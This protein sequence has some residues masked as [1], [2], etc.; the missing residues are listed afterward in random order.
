[1]KW[2]GARAIAYRHED[3]RIQLTGRNGTDY[4]ARFPEITEAL[5]GVPGPLVLDGEIVV[6]SNGLP[7][8]S[9]LQGR[10]HR[11]RAASVRTGATT[12]PA[13]FIAFD[14]L[15]TDRP[16][17]AEP[18]LR[19]RAVLEGLD[20]DRPGLR[21]PPTWTSVT[22]AYGWT[23]EHRLEGV[24][25]KRADSPYTPGARTRHW[26]KIKHLKTADVVLGGW[27][28]GGTTG[29]TVRA[30]L[31]GAPV[32]PGR[33]TFVGSVGTGFATAERRALAATLRRL[34]TPLSPFAGTAGALG[35]PRGT[36]IRFVR[37]ELRAEVEFLELTPAG[38]LRHPVWRGLR[39]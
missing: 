20:L 8:F 15:H 27:L 34:A 5:A 14:V 10:I 30:V 16:L 6:M 33:L 3:G 9:A 25:A 28:P 35:L 24:I 1:M 37:P 4:T 12:T 7:S 13:L 19:R 18:Y 2:D 32:E 31:V 38:R 39:G 17:L 23:R 11:T 21:V 26:I 22:D 36:E 29:T